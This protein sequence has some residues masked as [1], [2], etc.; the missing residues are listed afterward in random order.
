MKKYLCVCLVI[1]GLGGAKAQTTLSGDH[2]VDGDLTIGTISQES[3]LHVIGETGDTPRPG[4]SV[5]GEGGVIWATEFQSD[6]TPSPN[7]SYFCWNPKNASL[8]GGRY[9]DS[10]VSAAGPLSIAWCGSAWGENNVAF[11]GA[12][13]DGLNSFA[14]GEGSYLYANSAIALGTLSYA[15]CDRAIAIGYQSGANANGALALA[16]GWADAE[17]SVSIG[18]TVANSYMCT[19]LGRNNKHT[20]IF[21][22]HYDWRE[23]DP[24]FEIGNGTGNPSDPTDKAYRNALTVYKNGKITMDRQGDILMGEFGNPE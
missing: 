10:N 9:V 4:L 12:V 17:R 5:S 21:G 24:L 20:V 13:V 14:A 15:S 16:G 1:G 3:A 23:E 22:D 6:G 19:T 2:I 8:A 11:C 18:A 7:S